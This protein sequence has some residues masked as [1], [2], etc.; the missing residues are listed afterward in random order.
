MEVID[1][2]RGYNPP[3]DFS[4][5][6]VTFDMSTPIALA[7]PYISFDGLLAN[8]LLKD[9]LGDNFYNLPS[10]EP[11]NF[12]QYL[13]LPLK[14][15]GDIYHSSVS[16]FDITDFYI[17][18]VYKRFCEEYL[19][20]LSIRKKRIHRGSGFYKD[21]MIRLP[22]IPTKTVKFYCNGNLDEVFRLANMVTHLG[23]KTAYGF[24]QVKSVNVKEIDNDISLTRDGMAMRPIPVSMVKEFEDQVMLACKF[25][26]WDKR[27]VRLCVPPNAKV[28][29]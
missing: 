14:L 26:Y 9:I 8:V 6:E 13:K 4:P 23:K 2:V 24:G 28:R 7:H 12:S 15:Y 17:T 19:G 10:K 21:F 22:Y 20:H 25:P 1:R 3:T 11:I 27:N 5:L 16:I 18:T 29:L